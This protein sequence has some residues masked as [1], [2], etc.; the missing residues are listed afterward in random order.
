MDKS[1]PAMAGY[2]RFIWL[3]TYM[4]VHMQLGSS[5]PNQ[6]IIHIAIDIAFDVLYIATY[7]YNTKCITHT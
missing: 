5:G 3:H 6:T 1:G 4:Y 7:I 2:R